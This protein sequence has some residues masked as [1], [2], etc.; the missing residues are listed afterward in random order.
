MPASAWDT[1]ARAY[2]QTQHCQLE[3][4]DYMAPVGPYAEYSLQIKLSSP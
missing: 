4:K 1:P 2:S 3:L